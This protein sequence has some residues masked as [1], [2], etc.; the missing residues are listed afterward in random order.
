[1]LGALMWCLKHLGPASLQVDR[2]IL[3]VLKIII[4]AD[5][6]IESNFKKRK[7]YSSI[8]VMFLMSVIFSVSVVLLLVP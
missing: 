6:N 1:M 7:N 8:I 2:I 5:E 4:I 3:T